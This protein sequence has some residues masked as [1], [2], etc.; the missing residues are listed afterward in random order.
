MARREKPDTFR[1]GEFR[2]ACV[3]VLLALLVVAGAVP[4]RATEVSHQQVVYVDVAASGRNDGSCW[5]NAYRF[6][7]D[8]LADANDSEAP[9]EIRVALGVY[10][11]DTSSAC[12]EGTGD[13]TATFY[14]IDDVAIKGGF[15]GVGATDPNARD[16]ALYE[17]ILSGDLAGDDAPVLD[18]CDL[19][20]E[21]TRAENSYTVVTGGACSRSAILDGF[22]ITSGQ[23]TGLLPFA[24]GGLSLFSSIDGAPCCPSIRNCT[25]T[26]NSSDSAGAIRVVGASPELVNC[27]IRRNAAI[28]G[29]AIVTKSS[30]IGTSEPCEF[31]IRRCMLEENYASTN[32]G[33]IYISGNAPCTVEDCTFIE[34]SA[35]S[36]GAVYIALS[37]EPPNIANCRF[38]RNAA[39]GAGGAVYFKCENGFDMAS[40][41]LFGNMA[42]TGNAIA[43]LELLFAAAPAPSAT[44]TNTILWDG[45]EEIGIGEHVQ[46]NVTY[47]DIQSGWPGEGNIDVDPL[48]AD[49]DD[50]DHHLKSQTGRLDPASMT[51]VQDDV[52][53]HCIDAGDPNSP[54]GLEPFPN[55]G[56][57]NMGAYG[58]TAEASKSYFGEP[59]CETIIAGDINGDCKVDLRDLAILTSHWLEDRT[60][61]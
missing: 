10:R 29:G 3:C 44:I 8:A 33:A 42:Q 45:G 60:G 21:P 17:T 6:L 43:C 23:A 32:G 14:L 13:Q 46:M 57:V 5:A 40:C 35:R 25:F 11:P 9:V 52:T 55:G 59:V 4:L 50:S 15:A 18:P 53:S 7:Q 39:A 22:T 58:G 37:K 30:R 27:E 51:W 36:G 16:I 34:N 49:P 38:I 20:T 1:S 26:G 19:L 47:S 41:T 24:G 61:K 2:I 48:F 31:I 28:T 56:R 54:I 12:P